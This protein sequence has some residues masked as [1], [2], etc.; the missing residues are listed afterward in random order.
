M[1][2]KAS[3]NARPLYYLIQ[4]S[5]NLHQLVQFL[6]LALCA[7][8][9]VYFCTWHVRHGNRR[10]SPPVTY[11]VRAHNAIIACMSLL[12]HQQQLVV[13]QFG[14]CMLNLIPVAPAIYDLRRRKDTVLFTSRWQRLFATLVR[15]TIKKIQV[16]F[17]LSALSKSKKSSSCDYQVNDGF[18]E[19]VIRLNHNIT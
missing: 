10:A 12:L 8:L 4:H 14:R 2:F 16:P 15:Y 17:R 19:P 1:T 18:P 7:W 13:N 5:H 3:T 6:P 11:R 9:F